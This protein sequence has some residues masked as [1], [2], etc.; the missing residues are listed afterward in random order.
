MLLRDCAVVRLVLGGIL[1]GCIAG[2]LGLAAQAQSAGALYNGSGAAAAGR[3]GTMVAETGDPL[4]AVEDN[5]AGL[6]GVE[7]K[8]VEVSGVALLATG[9][10]RNSVST[11]N[12]LGWSAGLLP[13]GAAVAR[14]GQS[15]WRVAAGVTPDSLIRVNWRYL[16]PAGTAGVTYGLQSDRSEFVAIRSSVGLGWTMGKS[17]A[18]GA[19]VGFDYNVNAL[20]TPYIFQDQPQLKGLKV[21][22]DLKTRGF[23]WNGSAGLQWRPKQQLGFGLAW[24]SA[25]FVQSH[26]SADGSASA[27]FAVLGITDDATYHYQAE[28]DNHFPQ[29]A[30]GGF[31][32]QVKPR[33]RVAVEGDAVLWSGAFDRLPVKLRDGTNA[34]INSVVGSST[35]D[36]EIPLKWRNQGV[37][38]TGVEWTVAR[39]WV[40]RSGYS[41]QSDPVPAATITPMTAAIL[42]HSVAAGA[43]WSRERLGLDFAYQAQLPASES[44]GTSGLEAGEYS[45]SRVRVMTQAITATGRLRF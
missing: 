3:G 35:V 15:R 40:V 36:D 4:D 5:P 27:L 24:K 42:R 33:V 28:V 6:A 9:S 21:L 13:Y 44:V 20:K 19:T 12:A 18:A 37:V 45:N 11:G 43:G 10:F 41:F 8:S 31:Y 7:A 26:G 25:T 38:R 30:A 39:R 34:V 29:T 22:L 1:A 14:L 16:D 2:Y 32:W 23:G 17:L